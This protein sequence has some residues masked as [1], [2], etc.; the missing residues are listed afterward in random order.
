MQLQDL[1]WN[2]GIVIIGA[3]Y[4]LY[5]FETLAKIRKVRKLNLSDWGFGAFQPYRNLF[6]YKEICERNNEN[7]IWYKAQ[8]YLVYAFVALMIIGF[9]ILFVVNP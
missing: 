4:Y 3:I 2:I 1:I 5:I 6:E 7:L 8:I 9:G